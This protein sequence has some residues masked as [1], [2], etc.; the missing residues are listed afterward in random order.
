MVKMETLA[1]MEST[2][3]FRLVTASHL[4]R[5]LEVLGWNSG[6]CQLLWLCTRYIQRSKE[7]TTKIDMCY[8]ER[9]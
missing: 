9:S 3:V 8:D 5:W 7:I 2:A 1:I 4:T 6:R